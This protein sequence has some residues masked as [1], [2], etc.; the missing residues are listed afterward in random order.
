LSDVAGQAYSNLIREQLVEERARK[1]S[2]EQRSIQVVTT[3]GVLSTLLFGLAAFAKSNA[4]LNLVT[5]LALLASLV[6]FAL[7]F[8][9]GLSANRGFQY[10]EAKPGSL[11][12]LTSSDEWDNPH[13][14]G[15]ERRVAK[16][17][18][19]ILEEARKQNGKKAQRL[20]KALS[21]EVGALISVSVAVATVVVQALLPSLHLK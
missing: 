21:L 4:A 16:L 2:L 10:E 6:C 15:A 14:V 19:D 5:G 11:R 7:A 8:I 20:N 9:L 17:N 12:E 3:A 1:T 13:P 18:V